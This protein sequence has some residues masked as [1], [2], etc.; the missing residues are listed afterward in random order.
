M[1]LIIDCGSTKADWIL[2][3]END[4]VGRFNSEGFNPNYTDRNTIS[5]III[6]VVN[7]YNI[8][9]ITDVFFYGSGCAKMDN[10]MIVKEFFLSC[11]PDSNV[12]VF[13]DMTAACH[14]LLQKNKGVACILGTGSNACYYDGNEIKDN[15]VSLGFILGDEGSGSDIGK[16]LLHDYFY[17]IMPADLSKMFENECDVTLE[18]VIESVYK[19]DQVSRFLASFARF[20]VENKHDDYIQNL[21]H[22]SFD[23]FVKYY[24]LPLCDKNDVKEV[25]FVGSIAYFFQDAVNHVLEKYGLKVDK[26]IKNPIE[27]LAEYY[28]RY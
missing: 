4:V 8:Q 5:N 14:A 19:K 1:K 22:Q 10:R 25:S 23:D 20:A 13:H 26:V 12:N 7:E 15:A 3:E 18:S 6:S 28:C 27:G 24:V 21:C 9:N 2:V 16:R 11:F 17:K